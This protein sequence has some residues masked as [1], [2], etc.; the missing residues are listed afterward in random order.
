[1][2]Q[3]LITCSSWT[4]KTVRKN[5]KEIGFLIKTG[6]QYDKDIKMEFAIL[7]CAVVLLQGGGKNRWEGIRLPNGEEIG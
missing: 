2:E 5:D 3:K 1:M 6:W 4:I 7:K